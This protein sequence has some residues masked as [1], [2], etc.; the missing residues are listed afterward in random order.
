[1]I[2]LYPFLHVNIGIDVT[3]T[4][5]SLG[6][7]LFE[8]Q[9][10]E[11]WVLFATY[12]ANLT[13]SMFAMLPFGNTML[14]MNV[15][16]SAIVSLSA[17]I[18]YIFLKKKLPEWI[19]FLGI[20]MAESLCWCPTIILYNYL[21]YLFFTLLIVLLYMG[22][23][24]K[25]VF[26]F[27]AGI[28]LGLNVMV[29]FPNLAQAALILS[30]WYYGWL[31]KDRFLLVLQNTLL[32]IGG[33]LTGLAVVL[34]EISIQYGLDSYISMITHLFNM[35]SSSGDG[36]SLGS[37][38]FSIVDAY[39]V[40]FRWLLYPLA[41][42][43]AGLIAFYLVRKNKVLTRVGAVLYF[44]GMLL[45]LRLLYGRG[46]FNLKYYTYESMFQWVAIFLILSMITMLMVMLQKEYATEEKVLACMIL[47]IILVTPLGSD[48]YLYPIMNNL[49]LIAPVTFYWMFQ[50][51]KGRKAVL[52]V[53]MM[54]AMIIVITLIQSTAFGYTFVFRDGTQGE[55]LTTEV[56]QNRVL[57]GMKTSPQK[58]AM[59]E[60][61]TEFA[62]SNGLVGKEVILY[63]NIPAMSCFL[64]MP[65]ALTTSWPDLATYRV[66]TM[67]EELDKLIKEDEKPVIILSAGV[68]AWMSED[69]E[70]MT[71]LQITP[72]MYH[73]DEKVELI[74]QFIM[75]LQYQE[76]YAND[77][78]VIYTATN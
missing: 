57:K 67:K 12:L 6:S 11:E 60:S 46:M 64:E 30:V 52:P 19:V 38:L 20:F 48:N 62:D 78:F 4:G 16:T 28:I 66:E 15:Y 74:R 71:K 42:T 18:S 26:L 70:E 49:F 5:Y 24:Q 10:G 75:A 9:M 76:T 69:L 59:L 40:A 3:D 35:S 29:R 23:T 31:R 77:S 61:V 13:G 17:F 53:K 54:L 36:H 73:N 41:L 50:F 8:P 34:A 65:A 63:G 56:T 47:L 22:L 44:A 21:T 2:L 51:L 58:A 32:C 7:F 33:F 43:V 72:E 37:M 45:L 1:M 39:F 68:A 27:W 25:R 14:G 55:A